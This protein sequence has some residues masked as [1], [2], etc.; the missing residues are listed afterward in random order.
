MDCTQS[1]SSC[2]K[3]WEEAATYPSTH[4]FMGCSAEL[5]IVLKIFSLHF[6]ISK[7]FGT[8]ASIIEL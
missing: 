3:L 4:F 5:Q 6:K 8:K 1:E 2:W 7:P